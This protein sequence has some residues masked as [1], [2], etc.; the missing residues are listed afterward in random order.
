VV[1]TL[2]W[3]R[4][5]QV[6]PSGQRTGNCAQLSKKVVSMLIWP[7]EWKCTDQAKELLIV[8][9]LAESPPPP[10]THTHTHK[11]P[12]NSRISYNIP[13]ISLLK[14]TKP[15]DSTQPHTFKRCR[16]ATYKPEHGDH[17]RFGATYCPHFLDSKSLR[18]QS[19]V[20]S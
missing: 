3:P 18:L 9:N 15:A 2:T 14:T 5:W 1:R 13:S 16:Q 17:R 10:H 6:Y 19:R 7:R 8:L 12:Q 11:S 4:K 20:A